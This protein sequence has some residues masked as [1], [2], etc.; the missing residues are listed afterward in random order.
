MTRGEEFWAEC[1]TWVGTPFHERASIKGHGCD[2]K[3][4]MWGAA[5]ELGWPEAETFYAQ[6]VDYDLRKGI[7][8]ETLVEGMSRIFDRV[9]EP[10][11]GD[12]L[13]CNWMRRPGHMAVFGGATAIHTQING[14][15]Y[16]KETAMRV[17]TAVYPIHSIWRWRELNANS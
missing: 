5:R 9:D 4:L 11:V 6:F 10:A 17:L 3:G 8:H 16:V 13:L 7:P 1:L 12:I 15:A 2:C 14:K